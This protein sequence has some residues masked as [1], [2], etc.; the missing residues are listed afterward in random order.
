[1]SIL[2]PRRASGG[3]ACTTLDQRGVVRP[4]GS[5]CD[6]GAYEEVVACGNGLPNPGEECDAGNSNDKEKS[7]H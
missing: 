7:L 3:G 2:R 4:Q 6:I 5:G 1:M